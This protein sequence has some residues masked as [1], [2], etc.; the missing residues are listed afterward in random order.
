MVVSEI[1][2]VRRRN[3]RTQSYVVGQH[4]FIGMSSGLTNMVYGGGD[5][6]SKSYKLYAKDSTQR[7]AMDKLLRI[8]N[9]V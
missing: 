4:K 7:S 9:D 3:G 5:K 1:T 6:H 8:N 2:E